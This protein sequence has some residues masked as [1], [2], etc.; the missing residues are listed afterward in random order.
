MRKPPTSWVSEVR[1]GEKVALQVEGERWDANYEKLG[2]RTLSDGEVVEYEIRK[3]I[4]L[5][6]E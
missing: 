3:M 6:P 5:I 4:R 1:R 2:S